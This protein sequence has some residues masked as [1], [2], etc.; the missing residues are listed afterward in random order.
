MA[1][2]CKYTGLLFFLHVLLGFYCSPT[3]FPIEGRT[4]GASLTHGRAPGKG[5]GAQAWGPLDRGR[6]GGGQA[7]GCLNCPFLSSFP[8]SYFRPDLWSYKPDSNPTP[9]S[10]PDLPRKRPQ[11]YTF[12]LWGA[13][14]LLSDLCKSPEEATDT[15]SLPPSQAHPGGTHPNALL[16]LDRSA[17]LSSPRVQRRG[18]GAS[19]WKVGSG[20]QEREHGCVSKSLRNFLCRSEKLMSKRPQTNRRRQT[21]VTPHLLLEAKA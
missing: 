19:L 10:I 7:V 12:N 8:V 2:C 18:G 5:S 11:T 16:Y 17:L 13:P 6:R 15:G 14:Q 1:S 4:A 21:S 20:E 3:A 9:S